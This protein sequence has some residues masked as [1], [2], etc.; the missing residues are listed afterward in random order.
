MSLQWEVEDKWNP[1]HLWFE[2]SSAVAVMP[3]DV[4]D[5]GSK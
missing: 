5:G 3:A 2:L 1:S 4:V